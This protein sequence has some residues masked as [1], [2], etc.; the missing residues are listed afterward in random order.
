[1]FESS[2][3]VSTRFEPMIDIFF[4]CENMSDYLWMAIFD[5]LPQHKLFMDNMQMKQGAL[6]CKIVYS[7]PQSWL[8]VFE[9]LKKGP[10]NHGLFCLIQNWSEQC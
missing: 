9:I 4:L 7:R 2:S 6:L 3:F 1:M 5:S 8:V 10:Q